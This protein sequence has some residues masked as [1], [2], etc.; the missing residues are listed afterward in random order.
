MAE[1]QYRQS[2]DGGGTWLPGW[3]AIDGSDASTRSHTVPGLT[4]GQ[5]YT[6]EVRARNGVGPGRASNRDSA[7]P[8]PTP[9][10]IN[11]QPNPPDGPTA[12]S[13]AENGTAAVASYRLSDPD[14]GDALA[15]Q[16]EGGADSSSFRVDAVRLYFKSAPDFEGTADADRNDVY[17]GSA[18]ARTTGRCRRSR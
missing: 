2:T 17:D 16:K 4:N 15:L 12:V 11:R 9:P 14:A 1:Y 18:C 3:T 8:T 13:F 7:T 6:F 10:P 5:P